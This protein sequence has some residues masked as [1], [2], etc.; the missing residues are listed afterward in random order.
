[1]RSAMRASSQLPGRDPLLWIW[2]MYLH[3][4]QK[5]DDDDD[6]SFLGISKSKIIPNYW[7]LS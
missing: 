4:I 6:E 5:S 3:V 2:P 7:Y 1:M